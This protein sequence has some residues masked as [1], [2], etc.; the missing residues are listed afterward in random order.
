MSV[1]A[2]YRG[3]KITCID[4]KWLY[5]DTK[6]PTV[7]NERSCCGYC[8]KQNTKEG[9][10]SCLGTL[11]GVMNACCGHGEPS[12]AYIQFEKNWMIRGYEALVWIRSYGLQIL[13]GS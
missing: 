5:V 4:N 13:N 8:H 10:D 3:Y 2:R 7:N 1:H 12:E 11:I 6:E 9:H